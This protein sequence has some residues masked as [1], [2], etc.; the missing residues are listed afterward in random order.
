M[1][2]WFHNELTVT[3]S[4]EDV[5]A[6]VASGF[7]FDKILPIPPT[8][9]T[10][11][12]SL[13]WHSIHW[14]TK[15]DA[16]DSIR[17]RNITPTKLELSCSTA[18]GA[19]HGI[20][21]YLTQIHPSLKITNVFEDVPVLV[22]CAEYQDGRMKGEIIY[23]Y[24]VYKMSALRNFG[25]SRPWFHAENIID[26]IIGMG[27]PPEKLEEGEDQVV[28]AIMDHSYDEFVAQCK[29]ELGQS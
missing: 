13:N 27:C 28:V 26:T 5:A 9:T 18:N 2:N 3:G 4:A 12:E 23:P 20:L 25:T 29:S 10:T 8:F 19:P 6:F 22:G 11:D 24:G 7:D 16:G 17:F 15:W 14:G 21:A 1:P